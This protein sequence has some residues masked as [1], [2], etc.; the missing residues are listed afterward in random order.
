MKRST[1]LTAALPLLISCAMA[2]TS[3]KGTLADFVDSMHWDPAARGPLMVL[4]PGSVTAKAGVKGLSA[5]GMMLTKAQGLSAIV[6]DTMVVIDDSMLQPPNL[7]D[8]LPRHSKVLYLLTTLTSQQWDAITGSGLGVADLTADQRA[9]FT[10]I[11]PKPLGEKTAPSPGRMS[12]LERSP[13]KRASPCSTLT[14]SRLAPPEASG[15]PE[16]MW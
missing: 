12:R 14:S 13:T 2:Q 5:F 6:P 9:V 4:E 16:S 7:Y 3:P 1:A 15:L 11:M 8:G 10:S